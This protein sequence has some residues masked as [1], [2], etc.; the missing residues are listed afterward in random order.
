MILILKQSLRSHA[1]SLLLPDSRAIPRATLWFRHT[2]HCLYDSLHLYFKWSQKVLPRISHKLSHRT[3]ELTRF[4]TLLY[5][6]YFTEPKRCVFCDKW[7]LE[8]RR[9]HG[10]VCRDV[11]INNRVILPLWTSINRPSWPFINTCRKCHVVVLLRRSVLLAEFNLLFFEIWNKIEV[12]IQCSVKS[13]FIVW[14]RNVNHDDV[15]ATS[16]EFHWY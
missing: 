5:G 10:G 3:S 16:P 14:N 6:S 1:H 2:H 15:R 9:S 4:V 12:W 7:S 8:T 13:F 11:K